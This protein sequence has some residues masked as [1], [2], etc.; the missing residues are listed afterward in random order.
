MRGGKARVAVVITLVAAALTDVPA[1]SATTGPIGE[2]YVDGSKGVPAGGQ[3]S[4]KVVCPNDR[5]V[6]SGGVYTSSSSTA[7]SVASNGAVD[8][9]DADRRPDDAWK[10]SI[11]NLSSTATTMSVTAQCGARSDRPYIK[12]LTERRGVNPDASG[13]TRIDC[14]P[15]MF[16][17]GGGIV[18]AERTKLA[19]IYHSIPY[20]AIGED[21][22]KDDAWVAAYLN[23]SNKKV[24][25]T[26]TVIC[27]DP[28]ALGSVGG[29]VQPVEGQGSVD[30]A[31]QEPKT[32]TCPAN[33]LAL[34][35]GVGEFSAPPDLH[36]NN[37]ASIWPDAVAAPATGWTGWMNNLGATT[38]TFNVR[39]ICFDP[40]A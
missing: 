28:N 20:D 38:E 1:R 27:A 2:V 9:P 39:V 22:V 14:P 26:M 11:N 17:T 33:H 16:V 18:I 35:G 3:R 29:T 21:S 5:P 32:V 10:G 6:L 4:I 31:D 34:G 8:G 24:H 15:D 12:Y 13:G 36:P 30:A 19:P 40:Y 7:A 25:E 37:I 23:R